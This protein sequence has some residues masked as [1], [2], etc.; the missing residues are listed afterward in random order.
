VENLWETIKPP[1]PVPFLREEV[2]ETKYTE[3]EEIVVR[4][5]PHARAAVIPCM[6]EALRLVVSEWRKVR[7]VVDKDREYVVH[8]SEFLDLVRKVEKCD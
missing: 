5:R 7:L 6:M 1:G 2:M 3:L 8:P 4:A